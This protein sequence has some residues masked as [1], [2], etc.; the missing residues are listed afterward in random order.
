[1]ITT[2]QQHT[3]NVSINHFTCTQYSE[4]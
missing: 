4:R 1:M 2:P 3:T